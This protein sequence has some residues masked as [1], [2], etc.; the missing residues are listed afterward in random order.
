MGKPEAS[1]RYEVT[2]REAGT[3]RIAPAKPADAAS[4]ALPEAEGAS[5]APE[6]LESFEG[7]ENPLA[8]DVATPAPVAR[9]EE[10]LRG[11]CD[12][13]HV[14]LS[15]EAVRRHP[16]YVDHMKRLAR[17]E[18][19]RV[20]CK[21]QAVHLLDTARIAYIRALERK[22]PFRKEV[23]YAAALLHDVGKAE[24][25]ECGEPH[26]KAGARIATEILSD[27]DGFSAL[28]KTAIVAAVAQHRYYSDNASPL[29]K[30]LFEADK[31]SRPCFACDH[32]DTCTWPAEKQNAGVKV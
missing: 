19:D 7:P 12:N 24:Q 11:M 28:E 16:V 14:M 4:A 5:D 9:R 15:V 30:L 2:E 1:K 31:A 17:L 25:Y 18:H 6:V 26:E 29:G 27:V 13:S 21:H 20:Y 22:M 32:R 23:I 3:G 10:P 8:I